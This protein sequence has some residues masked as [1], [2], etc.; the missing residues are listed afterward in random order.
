PADPEPAPSCDECT[1]VR[2]RVLSLDGSPLESADV[3]ALPRGAVQM[4]ERDSLLPVAADGGFSVTLRGFGARHLLFG[5]KGYVATGTVVHADGSEVQLE[6]RLASKG[7]DAQGQSSV[8]YVGPMNDTRRLGELQSGALCRSGPAECPPPARRRAMIEDEL[9]R[10]QTPA[11]RIALCMAY[12]GAREPMAEVHASD[13]TCAR[14]L[15]TELEPSSWRWV[16]DAR[17]L[18]VATRV[19]GNRDYFMRA[20]EQHPDP[21]MAFLLLR[22]AHEA[23]VEAGQHDEVER[24]APLADD[25]RVQASGRNPVFN[26]AQT[27]ASQ[28]PQ[29]DSELPDFAATTI[30]GE[31]IDNDR[32]PAKLTLIHFW[33]TWCKGCKDDLPLFHEL[34]ATYGE[35][36]L[37]IVS[38]A[39]DESPD[40]VA[41]FRAGQWPM[42]WH[43]VVMTPGETRE[44]L[45]SAFELTAFPTWYLVD[46]SNRIVLTSRHPADSSMELRREAL[47]EHV[48][49][50]LQ[51]QAQPD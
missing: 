24:L 37:A 17:A 31:H 3:L 12:L 50:R 10:A 34:I 41:K 8:A 15:L 51:A 44:A 48:A 23:A 46:E 29:P 5:A 30:T 43:H 19:L 18:V 35:A 45:R 14:E 49:G 9:A 47:R 6:V 25:P 2:G 28:G 1:L 11:I 7:E 40:V 33:G 26:H 27:L 32:L 16:E 20:F 21:D 4:I 13:E 22:S 39:E 38:F 42:P 36:G